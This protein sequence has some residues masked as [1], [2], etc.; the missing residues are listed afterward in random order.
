M[1]NTLAPTSSLRV[2]AEG[3]SDE[4]IQA[5][6]HFTLRFGKEQLGY[7]MMVLDLQVGCH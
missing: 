5:I 6:S 7:D 1:R 2:G 3:A 4:V